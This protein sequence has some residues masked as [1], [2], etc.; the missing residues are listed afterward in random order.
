M[1]IRLYMDLY[2]G[3]DIN[4]IHANTQCYA[5]CPKGSTRYAIDVDIPDPGKPDVFVDAGKAVEIDPLSG[6]E[7]TD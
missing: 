3:Q 4:H 5:V 6:V 7:K 2:P 1:K